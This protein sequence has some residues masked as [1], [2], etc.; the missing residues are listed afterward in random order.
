MNVK[1]EKSHSSRITIEC[2]DCSSEYVVFFLGVEKELFIMKTLL[3]K[4]G[5][6]YV[7]HDNRE[8]RKINMSFNHKVFSV[9]LAIDPIMRCY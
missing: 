5:A 2:H 1:F 8:C 6:N 3:C 4:K 9:I 7:F